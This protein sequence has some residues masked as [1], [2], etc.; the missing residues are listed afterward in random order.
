VGSLQ[1][2]WRAV[3]AKDG[4][5]AETKRQPGWFGSSR[6]QER[7]G[8]ATHTRVA[9]ERTRPASPRPLQAA[10]GQSV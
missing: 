5:Q 8:R 4:V 1:L 6:Q 2:D 7:V 10:G 9:R 3:V